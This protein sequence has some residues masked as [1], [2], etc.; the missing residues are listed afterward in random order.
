PALAPTYEAVC[1]L[2]EPGRTVVVA[3][4]L[5]LGARL[6]QEKLGVPLLTVHLSPMA[7]RS[8]HRSPV[9]P[10]LLMGDG[11]PKPLKRAQWWLADT[12]VVQS[13]FGRPLNRFRRELGLPKVK[14]P[15]AS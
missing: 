10:G 2:Y 8:N 6:A 13:L 14:R 4:T 15:F 5:G 1:R 3:S 7:L 12:L 11:V 9:S